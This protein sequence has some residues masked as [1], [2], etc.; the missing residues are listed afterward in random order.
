MGRRAVTVIP[1]FKVMDEVN[2]PLIGTVQGFMGRRA[3]QVIR[4]FRVMD[5]VGKGYFFPKPVS[6]C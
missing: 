4:F 3:V 2:K 5:W 6:A 1:F